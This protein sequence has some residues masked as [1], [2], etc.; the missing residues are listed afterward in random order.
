MKA[1]KKM[2]FEC[3]FCHGGK[4]LKKIYI[5][6][7]FSGDVVECPACHEKVAVTP[8][9]RAQLDLFRNLPPLG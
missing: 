6:V 7:D 2:A 1:E 5:P 3:P 4:E 9:W 8:E